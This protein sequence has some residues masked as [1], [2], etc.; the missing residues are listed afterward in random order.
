[1]LRRGIAKKKHKFA[2]NTK[3]DLT[4]APIRGI[5]NV[6]RGKRLSA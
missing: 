6:Q 3:T 2:K 5:F 4:I 1:M